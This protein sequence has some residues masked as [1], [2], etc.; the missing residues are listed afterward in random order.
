MF[1]EVRYPIRKIKEIAEKPIIVV[2]DVRQSPMFS[3]NVIQTMC[4][5]DILPDKEERQQDFIRAFKQ[6]Y[7]YFF[8]PKKFSRNLQYRWKCTVIQK[9][10]HIAFLLQFEPYMLTISEK[11]K[12]K[13]EKIVN[14]QFQDIEQYAN[15]W[16]G[17]NPLWN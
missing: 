13:L 12:N 9:S 15:N 16:L 8:Q 7:D 2:F 4:L 17:S 1:K 3:L 10:V 14:Q 5:D 6:D 11:S